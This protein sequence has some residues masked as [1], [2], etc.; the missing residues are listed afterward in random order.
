MQILGKY[1]E[2]EEIYKSTIQQLQE[3]NQS[4]MEEILHLKELRI[5][6]SSN[7]V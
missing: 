2:N 6:K 5:L 1:R 3:N 4:L 7:N